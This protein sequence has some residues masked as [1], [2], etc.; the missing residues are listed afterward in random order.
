[1]FADLTGG[2]RETVQATLHGFPRLDQCISFQVNGERHQNGDDEGFFP[3]AKDACTDDSEA[4]QNLESHLQ[5]AQRTIGFSEHL[6]SSNGHA[7]YRQEWNQDA[8][9]TQQFGEHDEDEDRYC[10]APTNEAPLIWTEAV[11]FCF[12]QFRRLA[13]NILQSSFP[14]FNEFLI[15]GED[16]LDKDSVVL[17]NF[18]IE[19][20]RLSA[21]HAVK[22][23]HRNVVS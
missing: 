12:C 5:I 17:G 22:A 18:H 4:G 7:R 10:D 16:Q 14:C 20:S 2:S 19:N 13:Q 8:I 15:V 23:L 11:R 9:V 6:N 3:H 1:M 21:N